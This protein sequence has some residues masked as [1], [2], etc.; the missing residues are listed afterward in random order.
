MSEK[1][2][3]EYDDIKEAD[4][5]LPNW[6]LYIFAGTVLFAVCYWF[7]FHV[8][9]TAATP[10]VSYQR[11]KAA[12]AIAEAERLKAQ[13]E[14]TPEKLLAMSHNAAILSSGKTTFTQICAACHRAD[15]GG[16]V[17][18]N[19]TDEFW[20]GGSRPDQILRTVREGRPDKGMPAWGPQLGEE[21]VRDV[22]AY[23]LSIRNTH[24]AGG[25]APQGQK[26][27]I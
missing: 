20:I 13:G 23:V 19:L 14:M 4:N 6:W 10:L 22:A 3:H 17:G 16:Q 8:W 25:K 24:V 18:P 12:A 2:I 26:E 7:Y 9:G 15:G 11:E 1:I 21:R 5:R 27:E